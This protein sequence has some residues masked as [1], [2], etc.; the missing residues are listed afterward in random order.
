MRA[1]NQRAVNGV[2]DNGT[3]ARRDLCEDTWERLHRAGN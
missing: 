2:L 1:V 3:A